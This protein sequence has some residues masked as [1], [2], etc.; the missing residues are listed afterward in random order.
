MCSISINI[1][2]RK[3][4]AVL[5]WFDEYNWWSFQ[6]DRWNLWWLNNII[7]WNRVFLGKQSCSVSQEFVTFYEIQRFITMFRTALLS[8]LNSITFLHHINSILLLSSHVCLSLTSN[9]LHIFWLKFCL[10]FSFPQSVTCSTYLILLD[11]MILITF[12]KE[13]KLWSS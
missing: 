6:V 3:N 1:S 2:F 9:P 4:N 12:V 11:F 13:Y 7:P 8:Q 10:Q 5:C